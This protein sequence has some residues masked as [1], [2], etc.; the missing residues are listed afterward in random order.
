MDDF[1]RVV[2]SLDEIS[3]E[4][5]PR[6]VRPRRRP[7]GLIVL[8]V[9]LGFVTLGAGI[10]AGYAVTRYFAPQEEVVQPIQGYGVTTLRQNPEP[11][12]I[13]PQDPSFADVIPLV[14]PSVVSISVTGFTGWGRQ[15][16]PGSGSGFIFYQDDEFVF[17]AT[18]NHVIENANRIH[19][20]IDDNESVAAR[21]VGT[22]FYSDL[23]VLAVAKEEL[24]EKGVPFVVASF[25]NSDRMRMGD[26]VVA[27]GNSMGE[28]QIVTM[29]IISATNMQITIDER[30]MPAPLTLDVL[31][32]DAAVN[33]GNSG[34]PLINANGEIIGIV[35]AKLMGANIEGMGYAIPSNIAEELLHELME[36]GTVRMPFI[37]ISHRE[38][39]AEM[40]HMFN[41]PS[42]GILILGVGPDT[43]AGEAGLQV[44]DLLVK[45]GEFE[46][47]SFDDLRTALQAYRPG[48]TVIFEIYRQLERME[49]EITLGSVMP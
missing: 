23:A 21:V 38:I 15:E 34:G 40:R 49:V 5:A 43:P 2:A 41:L 31:Q 33:R 1:T 37:G 13:N 10:G 3:A 7:V 25:G 22:D 19:V 14:K 46:I 42:Q 8:L 18:N 39:D 35:T 32:T 27:I 36:T 17:I 44:H 12:P 45:F 9:C 48:D 47:S 6:R 26:L 29:G 30:G 20:S 4:Q 16:A 28:G 11:I 24:T